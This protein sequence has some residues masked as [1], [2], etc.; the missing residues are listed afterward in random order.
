[1]AQKPPVGQGLLT[2]EAS[3]SHSDTPH[4]VRIHWKTDRPDAETSTGQHTSVT[5][6]NH[7][8]EWFEPKIPASER[9]QTHAVDLAATGIGTSRHSLDIP[10]KRKSY[11]FYLHF[12]LFIFHFH[13]SLLQCMNVSIFTALKNQRTKSWNS[14]ALHT[15][16]GFRVNVFRISQWTELPCH[17]SVSVYWNVHSRPN[18]WT[19]S[20]LCKRDLNFCCRQWMWLC[21]IQTCKM[22]VVS[23]QSMHYLITFQSNVRR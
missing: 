16:S 12:S 10:L 9:P 8:L 21:S 15:V 18:K 23:F 14:T 2:I 6:D 13:L 4:S 5:W 22:S 17:I 19:E 11:Q 3:R 1:M 20:F 7:A